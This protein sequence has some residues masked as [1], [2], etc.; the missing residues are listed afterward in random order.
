MKIKSIKTF[1]VN[2]DVQKTKKLLFVKIETDEDIYGWGECYTVTEREFAI[3]MIVK[4][5][6]TYLIGRSPFHI[7][8]FTYIMYNDFA[9]K[10]GSME[11][12]CAMSGIEQALWDIIGKKL[13]TPVYNLLG[14]PCRNKIRVYAN[15]WDGWYSDDDLPK[16]AKQ[17][18][19]R[20]FTALKF[21]PFYGPFRMHISKEE[22]EI[23]VNCVKIIREAV[24][25]QID[26]LIEV[27]RRLAPANA[28][29]V[30]REIEKYSPF[31]Y[32]EPVSSNNIDALV[33]VKQNIK[34]P[35]VAGEDLY[36]KSGFRE[37]FEK[38][39]VDIINPD[40]CACGGILEAKEI[41][42]MA[43]AY[44]ICV[45]PHN[46]NSTTIGL[47]A[48]IQLCAVIPNFIIT[49]Y[50]VNFERFGSEICDEPLQVKDSYIEI[51]NKPGLG[52]ELNEKVLMK[53][54]HQE[55]PFPKRKFR[56]FFEETN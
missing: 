25:T 12:Y 5:I 34:H 35:M 26:L 16:R 15:G 40:I 4:N 18:V 29:N 39:A 30:A 17:L 50:F 54:I 23:A 49:E 28:I 10:R 47:A 53:F 46:C 48:T 24:G 41:S 38:R 42:A 51:P 31:W 45:S 33:E 13:E 14:G 20:G 32:E 55:K 19:D 43:E 37:L 36:T 1:L 21:D 3:E 6:S 44:Y 8:H 7:K 56:Y 27:H 2:P 22:E 52:I 9:Y 11:F